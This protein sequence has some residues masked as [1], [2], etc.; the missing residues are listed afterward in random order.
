MYKR[1]LQQKHSSALAGY[2]YTTNNILNY[3]YMYPQIPH[4]CIDANLRVYQPA[5]K[6]L[7]KKKVPCILQETPTIL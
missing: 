7:A 2:N 5:S 6:D 4:R 1:Y 3:T